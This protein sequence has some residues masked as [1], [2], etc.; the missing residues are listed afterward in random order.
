M[1]TLKIYAEEHGVKY[2]T[3][4]NRFKAG[5]IPEAFKDEFGRIL[6]PD[7][8]M[9]TPKK[10]SS[11]QNNSEKQRI[12]PKVIPSP[13]KEHTDNTG[14]GGRNRGLIWENPEWDL[15]ETGRILDVESIFRQVC[16]K[17]ENLFLKEGYE[18]VGNN[19]DRIHYIETRLQ[20]MEF[21]TGMPF[22]VLLSDTIFSLIQQSNAFW[23][24]VR[25]TE[26]SGGKVR[27]DQNGKT[28]NPVAGYFILPA[29]TVRFQRDEYGKI[30]K[31]RQDV[32]GKK[33][34]EF[35]PED[36]IHFYFNKRK[37]FSIGTPQVVPVKD[38][39][40]ALRR[41]EENVEL[42]YYQHLFPLFHYQVGTPDQPSQTFPDGQTEVEVVQASVKQIPADGCWVTPERHKIT[43]VGAQGKSLAVQEVIEYFKS[44]IYVGL[45]VSPIDLGEA[46]KAS[47]STAQ[48][49]SR[50]LID[51]TKAY[52]KK[53]GAQFYSYVI[54][55]L[56][57]ESSFSDGSLLEKDNQV[58][59][60]FAEID[61]EARMAKENH[62]VDIFLKNAISH[63]ELR[64][65]LGRE[66]FT[67]EDWKDTNWAHVEREKIV[68]QAIDEPGTP[69]SKAVARSA[70]KKS[71]STEKPQS[72]QTR[73]SAIKPSGGKAVGNKNQPRNQHGTRK[74]AKTNK[75]LLFDILNR[76]SP[77]KGNF[78]KFSDNLIR[79]TRE[80]GWDNKII[81]IFQNLVFQSSATQL[82]SFAKRAY[83]MGLSDSRI[84]NVSLLKVDKRIEIEI[85]NVVKEFYNSFEK[86]IKRNL[87]M[88]K[89]FKIEDTILISLVG[90][91]M[92]SRAK[93]IEE[94]KIIWAYDCGVRNDETL[95]HVEI[96]EDMEILEDLGKDNNTLILQPD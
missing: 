75:D 55:E 30:V 93:A 66:P 43:V 84:E 15:Y 71:N 85:S 3:A 83:R 64:K 78:N 62:Y 2:H 74:S 27:V 60:K 56:L 29:E 37:G 57:L 5:K 14:R 81:E 17:K 22:P 21:A 59:L 18:F 53:F 38:D 34:K 41:I 24:K 25:K 95:Q 94:D 1:R 8:V 86:M 54:Q 40:R 67:E 19:S 51:N 76:Q 6:I 13:V 42:L 89:D 73:K 70:A 80:N 36:V 46:G 10:K 87:S 63:S 79:T 52:Q 47:R 61:F 16:D 82:S 58:F 91:I 9:S 26:A 39:M 50:N 88:D 7:D 45:G 72:L 96:I 48:T 11:R 35:K 90:Q 77:L 20:Q 31:Y 92:S 44:R 32:Y 23:V 65:E 4:W 12:I 68:L 33:S 28:L 49:V 69:E